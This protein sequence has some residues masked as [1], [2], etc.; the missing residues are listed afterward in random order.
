MRYQNVDLLITGTHGA[1]QVR[2][3][4]PMGTASS[5]FA[6]P[7]SDTEIENFILKV[8]PMRRAVRRADSPQMKVVRDFGGQLFK[9][10]FADQIYA[11]LSSSLDQARL[12]DGGIRLRIF[13]QDVPE[14]ANLPW[15]FL[16]DA[17]QDSF[18]ALSTTTPIVRFLQLSQPVPPLK[19]ARPLRILGIVS[20]PRDAMALDVAAEKRYLEQANQEL[21][22]RRLTVDLEIDW[23]PQ[24]TLQKLQSALRRQSYHILHFVGHGTFDEG[25]GEGVLVFENEEGKAQPVS[26]S[27]LGALL[28]DHPTLRLAVLNACEGARTGWDDPFG[29]VAP[30]LVRAGLPAVVAM[31]FEVSDKAAITFAR[32]FYGAVTDSLPV[33]AALAEARKAILGTGN[34]VEWGTPVLYSRVEDGLLF[35]VPPRPDTAET[36]PDLQYQQVV[37]LVRQEKWQAAL[38]AWASLRQQVPDYPD[39]AL[40]ADLAARQVKAAELYREMS[41]LVAGR[42][43]SKAL[44]LWRQILMIDP[45]RRDPDKLVDQARAGLKKDQET[46]AQQQRLAGMYDEMT[47][48]VAIGQWKRANAVW[49][50][51][52]R[53]DRTYPDSKGLVP[54]IA[55]GLAPAPDRRLPEEPAEVRKPGRMRGCLWAAIA[56]VILASAA[57]VLRQQFLRAPAASVPTSNSQATLAAS[58]SSSPAAVPTPNEPVVAVITDAPRVTPPPT[59]TPAAPTAFSSRE[60][61]SGGVGSWSEFQGSVGG[62]GFTGR[63]DVLDA[64]QVDGYETVTS[65]IQLTGLQGTSSSVVTQRWV[66]GALYTLS[67]QS[68]ELNASFLPPKLEIPAQVSPGQTWSWQGLLQPFGPIHYTAAILHIEPVTVPAGTFSALHIQSTGLDYFAL[69]PLEFTTDSW[70]VPGVGTVKSTTYT[71]GQLFLDQELTRYQVVP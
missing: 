30:A 55:A 48:L 43:W 50:E 63:I 58:F 5:S 18:L 62:F 40:V 7:F 67:D 15:E 51:I 65:S 46:A 4:S 66:D 17:S 10:I 27:V 64:R 31:Q 52:Q 2:I 41:S 25:Q 37:D 32:E 70:I 60:I 49:N 24:A 36:A 13:T 68:P 57:L 35:Q 21:R 28:R 38:A 12:Q 16:Y 20:S 9:A 6:L 14:L 3:A 44:D 54:K 1:Y 45:E 19:V 8:G 42:Q 53:I 56:L 23:L 61:F 47:G 22:Q 69:Q 71:A 29:G 59:S 39:K 34:E 33:D 11:R 26:A